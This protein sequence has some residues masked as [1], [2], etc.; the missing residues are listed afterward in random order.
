ML[1]G[2][3]TMSAQ[4]KSDCLAQ[5]VRQETEDIGA[6]TRR[7]EAMS[8]ADLVAEA[9]R[10]CM[11]TLTLRAERRRILDG[12]AALLTDRDQRLSRLWA[13]ADSSKKSVPMD[14][15]LAAFMVGEGTGYLLPADGVD[16]GDE[17]PWS[18]PRPETVTTEG[19][20][21]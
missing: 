19:G 16:P 14:K 5:H 8:H 13:L 6:W 18:R 1:A 12:T 21:L 4:P 9:R 10:W 20:V 7:F 17:L 11:S 3:Y 15:F 2:R